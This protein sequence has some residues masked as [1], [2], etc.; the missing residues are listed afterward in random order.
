[1][2]SIQSALFEELDAFDPKWQTHYDT[3][4]QAADAA[5]VIDLY[6]AYTANGRR[7]ALEHTPDTIGAV[8]RLRGLVEADTI[9]YGLP[10]YGRLPEDEELDTGEDE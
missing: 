3:L 5:G 4:R 9:H 1:M 6:R 8:R 10:D 2:N 7:S